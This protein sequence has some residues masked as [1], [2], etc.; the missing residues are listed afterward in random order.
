[1]QMPNQNYRPLE[2][3]MFKNH[4]MNGIGN[5][6]SGN[7][8]GLGGIGGCQSQTK[9]HVHSSMNSINFNGFNNFNNHY[10]D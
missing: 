2:L 9:L 8:R 3:N 5:G 10:G 4:N 1:M 7:L 6:L